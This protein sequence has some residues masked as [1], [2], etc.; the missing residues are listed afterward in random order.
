MLSSLLKPEIRAWLGRGLFIFIL[1]LIV[2]VEAWSVVVLQQQLRDTA[3][4]YAHLL[5]QQ[6]YAQAQWTRLVLEY[7]HLT[8]PVT[9]EKRARRELGMAYRPPVQTITLY[10]QSG[11]DAD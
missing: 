9:L 4:A 5:K 3:A 1:A 11:H 10:R 6:R 7:E 8:S 2:L